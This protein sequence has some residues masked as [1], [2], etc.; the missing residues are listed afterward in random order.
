MKHLITLSAGALLLAAC[1]TDGPPGPSATA[2]V[3]PA[4]GSQVHGSVKFTQVGS[5]VRV[6]GEIDD[7][8]YL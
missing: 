1:A 6:E 5:R 2:S 4:S 7:A 3:R 8:I